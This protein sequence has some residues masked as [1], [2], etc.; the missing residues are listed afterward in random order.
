VNARITKRIQN[1]TSRG[2]RR[3]TRVGMS[4]WR[5]AAGGWL[6]GFKEE[7]R[8]AFLTGRPPKVAVP[9]TNGVGER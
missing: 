4:A 5:L 6:I 9:P 1:R 2:K 3:E 7:E 8:D